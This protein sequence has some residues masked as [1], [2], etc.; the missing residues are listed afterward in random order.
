MGAPSPCLGLLL[1]MREEGSLGLMFTA[2][3]TS[4]S[5]PAH[6]PTITLQS[7]G[8]LGAWVEVSTGRGPWEQHLGRA[9]GL[10]SQRCSGP[11]SEPFAHQAPLGSWNLEGL[12]F[13][14]HLAS[15]ISPTD[16]AKGGRA[17]PQA[18]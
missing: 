6:A 15:Y 1:Q 11:D 3:L 13:W 5:N 18:G 17:M 2:P 8:Y 14:D 4:K 9:K 12:R 7:M 16:A 10:R